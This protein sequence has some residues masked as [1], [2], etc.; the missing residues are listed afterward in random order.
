MKHIA[1]FAALLALALAGCAGT[2]IYGPSQVPPSSVGVS[3]SLQELRDDFSDYRVHYSHKRY[4][5]S[6]VVFLKPGSA[7]SVNL[8]RGWHTVRNRA[9]LRELLYRMEGTNPDLSALVP[10]GLDGGTSDV[11]GFIHTAGIATLKP[12]GRGSY[13]LLSVPKQYYPAYDSR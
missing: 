3:V 10:P 11:L 1:F 5:P 13:R 8:A 2:G 9:E 7:G 6:A 4:R 12:A